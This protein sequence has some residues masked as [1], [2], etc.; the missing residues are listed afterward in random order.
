MVTAAE[1]SGLHWVTV[2]FVLD[3]SGI[4]GAVSFRFS[5]TFRSL[6]LRGGPGATAG[7]AAPGPLLQS[8]W[9]GGHASGG[10]VPQRPRVALFPGDIQRDRLCHAGSGNAM[11]SLSPPWGAVNAVVPGA[12][13][14]SKGRENGPDHFPPGWH[15][16]RAPV[17]RQR[18]DD[19]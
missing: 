17:L 5:T 18:R 19:D 11:G 1:P 4:A 16:V 8:L 2:M 10:F 14:T 6:A 13:V 3:S 15:W 12:S 7:T 9:Q